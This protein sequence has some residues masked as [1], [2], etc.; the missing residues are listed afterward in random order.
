MTE[1]GFRFGSLRPWGAATVLLVLA[2]GCGP[3]KGDVSG[4][5]QYQGRP[6]PGGTITFFDQKHRV[7]ASPI[8]SDGRYAVAGVTAGPV[9]I[10]VSTPLPMTFRN[11]EVPDPK[12]KLPAI[13]ARYSDPD[14]SGLSYEVQTGSHTHD[15]ELLP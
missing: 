13:P 10:T 14:Q 4:T 15:I 9:K 7:T 12:D 8:G 2:A 3:G 1:P 5:V 6:L 11:G